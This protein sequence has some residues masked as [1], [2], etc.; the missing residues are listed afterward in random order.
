VI[1][2]VGALAAVEERIDCSPPVAGALDAAPID[3]QAK[4][5]CQARQVGR[6]PVRLGAS[7]Q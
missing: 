6:Q 4:A 5:G 7:A 1:E 2:S 3:E